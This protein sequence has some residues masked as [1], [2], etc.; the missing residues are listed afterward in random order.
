MMTP[1]LELYLDDS[2]ALCMAKVEKAD[3]ASRVFMQL[4]LAE[5]G[6]HDREQAAR[7]LGAAILGLFAIWHPARLAE[8][9]TAQKEAIGEA[10]A[11]DHFNS[12]MQLIQ[13][14]LAQKTTAF[15]PAIE[16]LLT[17]AA[18]H[19]EDARTFLRETWPILRAHLESQP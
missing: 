18:P 8:H 4:P 3:G 15:S 19:N 6:L 9:Y 10:N 17:Q 2:S 5:L 16:F 14:A 11:L 12:A 7:Q 1:R 13:Q